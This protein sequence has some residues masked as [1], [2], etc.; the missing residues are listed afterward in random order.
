M[1]KTLGIL[2]IIW[3]VSA[4]V[5]ATLEVLISSVG[6][7]LKVLISSTI[8]LVYDKYKQSRNSRK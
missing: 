4:K 8:D 1:L 6:A 7:T 2:M 5:G 3:V